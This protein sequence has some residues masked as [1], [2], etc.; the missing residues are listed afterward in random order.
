MVGSQI[1]N[2]TPSLSFCHNLCCR[3]PNGSCDH[4]FDIYT[5]IAFQWYKEHV[6]ARCFDLY[7][8]T[9]KFQES[10]W[11]TKSPFRECECHPPTLPKVGLWHMINDYDI[12]SLKSIWDSI[13]NIR[14]HIQ[15]WHVHPNWMVNA[16][17]R[18]GR[19]PTNDV[20]CNIKHFEKSFKCIW[21]AL[22]I[23]EYLFKKKRVS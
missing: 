20:S 15:I 3:C 22:H 16:P 4:I 12:L 18:W 14:S 19:K 17:T 13:L 21:K 6:S 1:S 8:Q 7:N 10:Q 2:L 23:Y 5:L 11:T 9:L